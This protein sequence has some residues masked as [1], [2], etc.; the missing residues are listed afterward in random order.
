ME[1]TNQGGFLPKKKDPLSQKKSII[2]VGRTKSFRN[3]TEFARFFCGQPLFLSF[4]DVFFIGFYHLDFSFLLMGL[5]DQLKVGIFNSK[6]ESLILKYIIISAIV[7][8][9]WPSGQNSKQYK[10]ILKPWQKLQFF[11]L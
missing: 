6:R 3:L 7:L 9:F 8:I 5:Y 2:N 10:I 11:H 1:W 4:L